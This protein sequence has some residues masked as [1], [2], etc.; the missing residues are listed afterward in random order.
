MLLKYRTIYTRRSAGN[1][2][3]LKTL[4]YIYIYIYIYI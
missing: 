4:I 3:R 1:I 2:T